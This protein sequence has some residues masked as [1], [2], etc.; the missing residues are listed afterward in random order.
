MALVDAIWRFFCSLKLTAAVIGLLMVGSFAGMFIDQT[1]TYQQH[2][3]RLGGQEL[4]TRLFTVLEL[5]DVFGSFWF[6]ALVLLLALN[7]VACTLERLPGVWREVFAT[8]P[9]LP[10]E[11]LLK[12]GNSTTFEGV[13]ESFVQSA[14][15]MM[16][17]L[18]GRS[19]QREHN[20]AVV[21][22]RERHRLMR[23]AP[24]IIHIS[25]LVIIFGHLANSL[26]GTDGMLPVAE[27]S[28][29]GTLFQSGPAGLSKRVALDF[30]VAC[31]DFRLETFV[32][33][34]P[35]EYESDLVILREGKEQ[36]T[37][38]IRVNDPLNYGGYTFYQS[39]Y[40][41]LPDGEKVRLLFGPRG[42]EL[43]PLEL[44]IGQRHEV[45]EGVAIVPVEL[46]TAGE[47]GQALRINRLTASGSTESILL[48]KNL[49]GMDADRRR[50][51]MEF[52]FVSVQRRYETILS[53]ARSPFAPLVFTGF[54]LLLLG[55]GA[56]TLLSHRRFWL[57][58]KKGKSG[59]QVIFAAASK[60]HKAGL[61]SQYQQLCQQLEGALEDKR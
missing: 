29:T 25:L 55:T 61:A 6:M 18:G 19:L 36:L 47:L 17:R 32:S 53:V 1:L 41:P 42:G 49:P 44:G 58:I 20:G 21:Y 5:H 39:S 56:A 52:R 60:R 43:A 11:Q 14:Q 22:F 40:R 28:K 31:S 48:L 51:Q 35:K 3:S 12:L 15:Q 33:G 24:V 4:K 50:G 30:E 37:K 34:Q 2:M 45:A 16:H 46:L 23:L 8:E 10:R 26:W 13:S 54:A 59:H 38:T 9:F 7:L 57:R 27:G